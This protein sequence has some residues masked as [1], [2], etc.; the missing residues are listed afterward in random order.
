MVDRDVPS[1]H[2]VDEATGSSPKRFQDKVRGKE[3]TFVLPEPEQEADLLEEENVELLALGEVTI[4]AYSSH[5]ITLV[6]SEK[7][8]RVCVGRVGHGP[9]S[10]WNA[11]QKPS[12]QLRVGDEIME[13]NGA[14]GNWQSILA[15]MDKFPH[16]RHMA[17]RVRRPSRR[18]LSVSRRPKTPVGLGLIVAGENALFIKEID[19]GFIADWNEKNPDTRIRAGDRIIAVNGTTGKCEDMI[20]A[21]QAEADI[22]KLIIET[23]PRRW[24]QLLKFLI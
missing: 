13:V 20:A 19:K 17:I 23:K 10:E 24:I 14:K 2:I 16:P 8:N 5:C 22:I 6:Y 7:E 15:K 21:L 11:G 12:Q 18:N 3:Q 1:P 4:E 9:W